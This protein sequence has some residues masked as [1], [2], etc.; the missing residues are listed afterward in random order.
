MDTTT[1]QNYYSILEDTL[2]GF[3]LKPYHTSI[4]KS[5]R[6][7]P[8]FYLFDTG[9][10]RALKGTL[11]IPLLPQTYD[12][13]EVFEH[14]LILEIIKLIE[15]SRKSWKYF[16]LLTK[17]G[18]EIDLILDRPGKTTLCIEIKSSERVTESDVRNFIRLGTDIPKSTLYCLSRD[19]GRKRIQ[20]VLCMEWQKD[21]ARFFKRILKNKLLVI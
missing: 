3:Y 5:Q 9:V 17:D 21:L 12:F 20:N 7:S 8:K 10:C 14:F 2:V 1:V 18:A 6:L 19:P 13:G 16:Y 11:N 4:R 15:Y